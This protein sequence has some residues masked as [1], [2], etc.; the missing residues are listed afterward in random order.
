MRHNNRNS[1]YTRTSITW[2]LPAGPHTWTVID[3]DDNFISL[4]PHPS[5]HVAARSFNTTTRHCAYHASD[6]Y[7]VRHLPRNNRV[8]K[9]GEVS[10]II[11]IFIPTPDEKKMMTSSHTFHLTGMTQARRD[12]MDAT[13]VTADH[14]RFQHDWT[15]GH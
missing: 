10:K 5:T 12:G 4:S 3:A 1:N 2:K 6:N 11:I 14:K 15:S 7:Y 9:L 13:P 8:G